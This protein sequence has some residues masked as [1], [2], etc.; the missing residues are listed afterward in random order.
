MPRTRWDK[1][2]PEPTLLVAW[3]EMVIQVVRG[4]I[5]KLKAAVVVVTQGA[6]P[7]R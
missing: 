4:G 6:V 7:T 2:G 3:I 5:V 1:T